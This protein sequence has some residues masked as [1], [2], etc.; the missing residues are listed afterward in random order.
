LSGACPQSG[1][2]CAQ[3]PSAVCLDLSV[4]RLSAEPLPGRA[5]RRLSCFVRRRETDRI[6]RI[7][8]VQVA[9]PSRAACAHN[10][11]RTIGWRQFQRHRWRRG[12]PAIT[13]CLRALASLGWMARTPAFG[14]IVRNSTSDT[15]H[16]LATARS[17][18]RLPLP[19]ACRSKRRTRMGAFHRCD[20]RG[21]ITTPAIMPIPIQLRS[22]RGR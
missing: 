7:A 22:P 2:C 13:L 20:W 17:G 15:W 10:L 19:S 6:T 8:T 1:V 12:N 11:E 14:L 3:V 18:P 16:P 21:C 9:A 5:R 4:R